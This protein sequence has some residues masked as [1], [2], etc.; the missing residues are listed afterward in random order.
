MHA[1]STVFAARTYLP[2]I[3]YGLSDSYY[4]SCTVS[5]DLFWTFP[6]I[7]CV[8]TIAKVSEFLCIGI[9]YENC[10]MCY[11]VRGNLEGM[12]TVGVNIGS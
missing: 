6:P 7:S 4:R 8:I 1:L 3:V 2:C 12:S 9:M 10:V 11:E 5:V